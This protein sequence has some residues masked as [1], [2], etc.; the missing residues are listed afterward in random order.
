MAET[1]DV[2]SASEQN[3]VAVAFNRPLAA[4]QAAEN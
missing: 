3:R 2:F 4:T 1:I